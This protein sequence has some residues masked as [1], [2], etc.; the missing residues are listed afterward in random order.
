MKEAVPQSGVSTGAIQKA[1]PDPF[2]SPH[3]VERRRD[4]RLVLDHLRKKGEMHRNHFAV[5]R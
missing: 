5:P 1:D 4:P 3:V 2:N